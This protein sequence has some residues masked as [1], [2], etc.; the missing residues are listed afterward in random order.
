MKARAGR[1]I[2]CNSEN[3]FV[4]FTGMAAASGSGSQSYSGSGSQQVQDIEDANFQGLMHKLSSGAPLQHKDEV[5][6]HEIAVVRLSK[7]RRRTNLRVPEA[8]ECPKTVHLMGTVYQEG[9]TGLHENGWMKFP[10][11]RLGHGNYGSVMLGMRIRDQGMKPESRRLCAI[12]VQ[13]MDL[14]ENCWKEVVAM[15]CLVHENIVDYYD[16]FIVHDSGKKAPDSAT[17]HQEKRF[18]RGPDSPQRWERK[19]AGVRNDLSSSSILDSASPSSLP[20]ADKP[21]SPVLWIMM[22]F[23]DAGTLF[24]EMSRYPNRNIPESG[25]LY[26]SKQVLNG[27]RYMHSREI[28][29]R[30]LHLNN[31]LL[32]YLPDRSKKCLIADFGLCHL[33]PQTAVDY[34][35]DVYKFVEGIFYML[36]CATPYAHTMRDW[37]FMKLNRSGPAVELLHIAKYKKGCP[38]TVEALLN[39]NWFNTKSRAPH[40]P[41]AASIQRR[42]ESRETVPVTQPMSPFVPGPSTSGTSNSEQLLERNKNKRQASTGRFI[43]K[44]MG[45][46][47]AITDAIAEVPHQEQEAMIAHPVAD[48]EEIQ[49]VRQPSSGRLMARRLGNVVRAVRSIPSFFYRRPRE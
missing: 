8:S 48:Q 18:G 19:H 4:N 49:P 47:Q 32:K 42:R 31:V 12:K 34:A 44:T 38:R 25:V 7:G 16:H 15:R 35:E 14:Q 11:E 6:I 2:N 24:T 22:E 36:S 3:D 33:P 27:L 1:H 45:S 10:S 37:Q 20:E 9:E 46:H 29:H 13:V 41:P 23:A 39:V 5:K 17:P 26:Y 30:D 21:A 28:A 43:R 40:P